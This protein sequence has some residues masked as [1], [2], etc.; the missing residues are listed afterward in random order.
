MLICCVRNS[1]FLVWV[2][3]FVYQLSLFLLFEKILADP[4]VS[5]PRKSDF[6]ELVGFIKRG[7]LA[8]AYGYG[9]FLSI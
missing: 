5:G 3:S 9:Q 8:R 4:I 1:H 7:V 6:S 2:G